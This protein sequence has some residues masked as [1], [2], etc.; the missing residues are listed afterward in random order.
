MILCILFQENVSSLQRQSIWAPTFCQLRRHDGYGS[1]RQLQIQGKKH[2]HTHFRHNM[3]FHCYCFPAFCTFGDKNQQ[4]AVCKMQQ[5]AAR[6]RP[7][8]SGLH[9]CISKPFIAS[10]LCTLGWRPNQLASLLIHNQW[11]RSS[12]SS[13]H[14]TA[15]SST[16]V[17]HL[18]TDIAFNTP[19]EN[20]EGEVATVGELYCSFTVVK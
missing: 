7:A 4:S 16:D 1:C 20:N 11:M 8:H 17:P 9:H 6:H 3:F 5:S 15:L 14:S 13:I 18:V 19:L 2:T 12:R 10:C